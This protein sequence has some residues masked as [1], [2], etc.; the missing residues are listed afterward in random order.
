M[1]S[2]S[3]KSI[4]NF[5]TALL[6]KLMVI[7][8]GL[9]LPRLFVT[10]YGS[11]INGLQSSVKQFFTY[12]A[13]LEAGVGTSALQSMYLPVATGDQKKTNAYLSA[14][15]HHYNR[16]GCIYFIVL[17][18]LAIGYAL[19]VPVQGLSV[20]QIMLYV[21]LSGATTG[22]SF[23]YAAKV[24]LLISAVGDQFIVN[25]I[26]MGTFVVS[27]V[28]KVA[29]IRLSVNILLVEAAF[30]A[31]NL[32]SIGVYLY[33]AKRKYSWLSF[34]EKPDF[35]CVEQKGSVM[36]HRIASAIF[37]NVDVVLLTLFCDLKTVSVYA[38]YKMVINM[39]TSV[40][41][42]IG[43]SVQ[44]V[45]GQQFNGEATEEKQQYCRL[46]DTFNVY[47]SAIA[48][49]LYAVAYVF[50]IP[51]MRL[52]TEGM[53]MNYI[54]PL[55]PVLYIVM[56]Y[57]MVGREAMMRT[58]EVAG[59][60][61]KTRIRTLIELIIN[62]VSSL[63]LMLYFSHKLGAVGGLYGVLAGTIIS[64]LY[65]TIDINIYAN[66][67]ILHRSAFKTFGVM[68]I[69]AVLF[70]LIALGFRSVS[71]SIGNYAQF[72]GHGCWVTV[73]VVGLFLLIQSI[74]NKKECAYLLS[75]V[76]AKLHK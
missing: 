39:V 75:Y 5:S 59:H 6:Y 22:I 20:P 58:I 72:I 69:N 63:V 29:L 46:I 64:L 62:V 4:L 67:N 61:K 50:L 11:E 33:V 28:L 13:L 14:V 31:V 42:E 60:F 48:F 53:D 74:V 38:M 12:I 51:F 16:T 34:S 8:V 47:Y 1:E 36:I 7:A 23:F 19:V 2:K 76:K 45:L 18:V 17:T 26:T 71:L 65:R 27:S 68:L 24:K 30:L 21:L 25:W 49:G 56:E 41:G 32:F 15:S 9:I 55:L 73:A 10:N 57:L 35:S 3:K 40:V 37:Q 70:A 66:K 52:Y 43:N 44:F 54:F